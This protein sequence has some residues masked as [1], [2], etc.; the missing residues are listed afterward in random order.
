MQ[1]ALLE[2]DALAFERVTRSEDELLCSAFVRGDTPRL[3]M[4]QALKLAQYFET[5]TAS[6]GALYGETAAR[7]FGN[8]LGISGITPCDFAMSYQPFKNGGCPQLKGIDVTDINKVL[9]IGAGFEGVDNYLDNPKM[10]AYLKNKLL[11]PA[12]AQ[13]FYAANA[14]LP[15]LV[16]EV[17]KRFRRAQIAHRKKTGQDLY[18]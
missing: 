1:I 13:K 8:R 5:W 4:P 11:K 12:L 2:A 17:N 10:H 3:L 9:A 7:H 6:R 15:P 18:L 16:K 14:N